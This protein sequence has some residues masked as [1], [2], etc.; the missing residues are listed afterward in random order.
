MET[1]AYKA[2]RLGSNEGMWEFWFLF[3]EYCKYN[4]EWQH[5]K[6]QA[7]SFMQF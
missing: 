7:F 2:A 3:E 1:K 6:Q 5:T 4:Y